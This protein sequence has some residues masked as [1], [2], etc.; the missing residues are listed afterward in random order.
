V[1]DQF[2]H[3]FTLV[4]DDAEAAHFLKS[5]FTAVTDPTSRLRVIITLRAD[6]YDRPLLH[7]EFGNL[8]RQRTEVVMPLMADE[9]VRAIAGPAERVGVTLEP[10]LVAEIVADVNEQP[11]ALP[12]LQY[13]LTELFEQRAGR[14]LT[15]K[16]YQSVG[17]VGGALARRAEEVYAG[18]DRAGKSATR[19][20]FLR[21][22]TLGEEVKD[23]RRQISLSE[24][25]T[26]AVGSP[27]VVEDPEREPDSY[28]P[29]S[30]E[31]L[32]ST[33]PSPASDLNRPTGIMEYV[34]E[35][36]GRSRLLSFDR[37][38]T[39]RT[40]TVQVA[41]S[42]LLREWR[43]LRDWLD[44]SRIDL[45]LQRLLSTAA[46]EWIKANQEASFL[47]RGARLA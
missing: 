13:A 28:E 30:D 41:H 5:L 25:I 3:I 47:L 10:G 14:H 23:T 7:P 17:G 21:L 40:P 33:Q 19:Q 44:A 4:D 15:R 6:F 26:I 27:E 45:R 37:D 20:L 29:N 43:R 12:L 1:I 36:F 16:A 38:P 31:G 42:A 8:L 2:E 22:V 18:L 32:P 39:T 46:D 11:S 24:L 9:L 35:A 34:I